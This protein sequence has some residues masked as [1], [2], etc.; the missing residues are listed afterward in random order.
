V[1]IDAALRRGRLVALCG[2]R[3]WAEVGIFP[4]CSSMT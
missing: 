2:F 4:P 3:L 1:R